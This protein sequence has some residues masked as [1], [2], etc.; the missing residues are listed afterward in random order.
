MRL[1][2]I[3]TTS[4]VQGCPTLYRTMYGAAVIQ[5]TTVDRAAL[6][7]LDA[8]EGAVE[9]PAE[10]LWFVD[11]RADARVLPPLA[12]DTV[13][14]RGVLFRT[15][16]GT[17]IV[18]GVRVTDSEALDELRSHGNGI[19]DYESAVEVSISLLM[20]VDVQQLP[21]VQL[22]PR[23]PEFEVDRS[24]LPVAQAG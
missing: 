18:Q 3:G 22:D 19:P 1:V 23:R 8:A 24:R 14:G 10:L 5:G 9:V 17:I 4:N 7:D 21:L 12:A 13:A 2:Y 6:A 15:E 20:S 11:A 16:R